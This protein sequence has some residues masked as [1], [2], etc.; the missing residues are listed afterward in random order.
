WVA[1]PFSIGAWLT[2]AMSYTPPNR[3]A[4]CLA[5]LP[6]LSFRCTAARLMQPACFVMS[7][8]HKRR[9][10]CHASPGCPRPGRS[11]RKLPTAL[12]LRPECARMQGADRAAAIDDHSIDDP[13]GA[14]GSALSCP[15]KQ[16]NTQNSFRDSISHPPPA[17]TPP[18]PLRQPSRP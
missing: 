11:R 4:L 1:A 15:A 10:S 18:S 2:L 3:H 13:Y 17:P 7:R 16:M 14:R 9:V 12:P 5:R 6:L 8:Q